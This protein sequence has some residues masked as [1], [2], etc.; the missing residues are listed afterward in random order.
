[1][2]SLIK[3]TLSVGCGGEGINIYQKSL[4][5]IVDLGPLTD[6]CAKS[7]LTNNGNNES[8]VCEFTFNLLRGGNFAFYMWEYLIDP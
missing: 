3:Y 2:C 6:S 8:V 7:F 5:I 4:F 1:M